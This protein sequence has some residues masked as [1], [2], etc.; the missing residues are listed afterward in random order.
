MDW[1]QNLEQAIADHRQDILAFTEDLIRIPSENPPGNA[2]RACLDRVAQELTRLGIA[3]RRIETPGFP[4]HPRANLLAF[5]GEGERTLYFHGHCDVVPAQ[6]SEQFQPRIQ[7]G[8]LHG[9]GSADMKAGVA[10]MIYAAHLLKKLNVPLRGRI[11]L[12]VVVDE[13]TGGQGGSRYLQEAGLLGQG[14]IAMV[15]PEPTSGVIWNANRGAITL[16]ITVL[17][18]PAHVG[19]QHMGVNA[20]ERMVEVVKDLQILKAEVEPRRTA[21]R[22]APEEAAHSILMLGG[23]VEGGTNFNVVP[24]RCS[25]TVERRFNPE[26]DFD[27]EKAK[28]FG[29]LDG[30]RRRGIELEVEILQECRSSGVSEDHPVALAL[31]DTIAQVMGQRPAFEMCPGSLEIRCYAHQGIPAFAYGPGLLE[32]A[33]GPRE[34]VELEQIYRHTLIYALYALNLLAG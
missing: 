28:L 6:S 30:L 34:S 22:I 24:E 32:V 12:C 26:E 23:R 20:F 8:F 14:A 27:T 5:T 16:K 18:K 31:A 21:Y 15:T 10:L 29:V 19:L 11:G 9:R 33:H 1:R 17:G 3:H 25:F 13:E 2:Y 4:E 7:D